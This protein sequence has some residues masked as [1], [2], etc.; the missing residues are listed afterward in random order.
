MVQFSF[1]ILSFKENLR[2]R[3]VFI[4]VFFIKSVRALFYIWKALLSSV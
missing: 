3:L 4:F 2:N 1:K